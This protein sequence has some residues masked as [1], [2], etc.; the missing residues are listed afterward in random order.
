[1]VAL[2]A[3]NLHAASAEPAATPH[4][5]TIVLEAEAGLVGRAVSVARSG[6][7]SGGALVRFSG[8][9]RPPAAG[10]IRV[11]GNRLLRDGAPFVPVGFTLVALTSP[12]GGDGTA[13][14]A[15][16]LD[17]TI[18][19][20]V[21]W[22]ADTIR[23]QLSQR[24]LDPTDPLYSDAY[25]ERISGGVA[26]A[27]SHGLVVMLSI[28][29]QALSGGD[30]H[31]QPSGATIRDWRTLTARFNGD[32]NVLYEIF[33]EPQNPPT[34]DGWGLWRN[35][36]PADRNQGT[37][38]VG[39]QAVLDA[40]RATGARNVVVADAAQFAQRLDGVPLLH[41]PLGQVAY[42]VHPYL[43]HTLR[44]PADWEPG[45]GF[46]STQ[47]P[48][49]ATE[50]TA[51]PWVRFCHPEWGT[52]SSQLLTFLQERDI[53][54]LAWALDVLNSLVADGHYTATSLDGFECGENLPFGPGE[55]FKASA[56]GWH[57][58]V[59][60]CATGLS[61]EGAVAFPV[62][63]PDTGGYRLSSRVMKPEN[64]EGAGTVLVQ[65]DDGCPFSPWAT[66][67]SD[68]QWSWRSAAGPPL[69]LTA[70]RHTVRFL[71]GDGTVELD[72]FVLMQG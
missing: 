5:P 70:G 36:G 16:R 30:S 41:D 1:V 17:S 11:A 45:F 18:E 66:P 61:D 3:A 71:G 2:T 40:I 60:P 58:H 13:W 57:P 10:G 4:G 38:A 19:Q 31:A 25:V 46:L 47:Y 55:L 65:V 12:S 62:D 20:T 44:E 51:V 28:Q 52:T 69:A 15:D 63:V 21:A 68:G 9:A 27:R 72:Q 50:W 32:P 49:I 7:A 34:P 56:A 22:G 35:G 53:G 26:L 29:D 33:N 39:H 8:P 37:P 6:T 59:A 24:G 54:M 64:S 43:T 48:V 14:A 67:A 23:F 42:G